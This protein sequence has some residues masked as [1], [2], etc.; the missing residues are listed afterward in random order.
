MIFRQFHHNQQFLWITLLIGSKNTP[1]RHCNWGRLVDCLKKRANK[2]TVIKQ[3]VKNIYSIA[4]FRF[5]VL[6]PQHLN[7]A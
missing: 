6:A 4:T 5:L 1:Q 7:C 2:K 3:S